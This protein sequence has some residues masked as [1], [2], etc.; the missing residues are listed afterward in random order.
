VAFWLIT[1][2]GWPVLAAHFAGATPRVMFDP[3]VVGA[4][5]AGALALAGG[6]VF[7]LLRGRTGRPHPHE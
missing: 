2:T 4:A 7:V 3:V 5:V 6:I 1:T